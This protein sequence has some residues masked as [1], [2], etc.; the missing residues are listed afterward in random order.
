MEFVRKTLEKFITLPLQFLKWLL[1]GFWEIFKISLW[2]LIGLIELSAWAVSALSKRIKRTQRL[3]SV[4]L[5]RNKMA[6]FLWPFK[7]LWR[8]LWAVTVTVFWLL[9][10]IIEL[11]AWVVS[12]LGSLL[13]QNAPAPQNQPEETPLPPSVEMRRKA[14]SQLRRNSQIAENKARNLLSQR[15][16]VSGTERHRQPAPVFVALIFLSFSLVTLAAAFAPAS[17]VFEGDLTVREISFTHTGTEAHTLFL[18]GIRNLKR[19]E[20]AGSQQLALTGN[21]QSQSNPSLN[22]LTKLEILLPN[23]TSKW[24]V[25][26]AKPEQSQLELAE[27]QLQPAAKVAEL[28]Y[29]ISSNQLALSLRAGE[30][31]AGEFPQPN[32]LKLSLG[33]QPVKVTLEDY[34]L[35]GRA[36]KDSKIPNHLE[37]ILTPTETDVKVP[38]GESARISLSLPDP[39]AVESE[40][41]L[42]GDLAVKDV[43]FDR[44]SGRA[45][46]KNGLPDSSIIQGKIRMAGRELPVGASQVLMAGKPGIQRLGNLQIH[47]GKPQGLSVRISGESDSIQ[48]GTDPKFPERGIQG[49][50]INRYLSREAVTVLLAFCA[51]GAAVLS[52]LFVRGGAA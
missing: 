31:R 27:L 41:W 52:W 8:G 15:N 43:R 3:L 14:M 44:N 35:P 18:N 24:S 30:S 23:E 7:Q 9:I 29:N 37:F 40:E 1:A 45:S 26:P 51:G 10:Q 25:E 13:L 12:S 28:S 32:L 11:F 17:Y 16:P 42:R 48:V 47:T 6:F 39:K 33:K 21:F 5:K 19:V 34:R 46:V 4:S 22:E 50:L 38:V 2:L 20:I 36:L 49:K